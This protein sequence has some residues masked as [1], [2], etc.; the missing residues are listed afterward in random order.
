MN[1]LTSIDPSL[2]IVIGMGIAAWWN[3][4]ARLDSINARVDTL[5]DHFGMPRQKGPRPKSGGGG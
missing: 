2:V 5:F 4:S 3:I 1:A